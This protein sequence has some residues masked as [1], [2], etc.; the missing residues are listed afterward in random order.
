MSDLFDL[1]RNGGEMVFEGHPKF[2]LL[3]SDRWANASTIS[4]RRSS[5][6]LYGLM[7]PSVPFHLANNRLIKSRSRQPYLRSERVSE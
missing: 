1:D 4:L 7:L 6:A 2:L 5:L 3:L